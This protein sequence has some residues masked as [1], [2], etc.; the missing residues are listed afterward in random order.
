MLIAQFDA[1]VQ[2][3]PQKRKYYQ[4]SSHDSTLAPHMVK[5]GI[6]D[7]KC[8]KKDIEEGTF[9]KDCPSGPPVASNIIW[10]LISKSNSGSHH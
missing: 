4:Y 3:K 9:T 7:W 5:M 2:N 8:L 6:F 1:W 10:E